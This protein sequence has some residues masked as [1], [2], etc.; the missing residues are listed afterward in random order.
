MTQSAHHELGASGAYRYLVC[1]GSVAAQRGKPEESSIYADEGTEAHELSEL[2]LLTWQGKTVVEKTAEWSKRIQEKGYDNA[3]MVRETTKYVEYVKD[4]CND[5]PKRLRVEARVGLSPAIPGGFSTA[6]AV[7]VSHENGTIRQIDIADLKYGKGKR[8]DA[9]ENP[10]L[11]LYAYGVIMELIDLGDID[12]MLD[13]LNEIA[14]RMHICQ[15]RLDHFDDDVM[16]VAQLL[17][18]VDST[19]IPSVEAIEAGDETRVAGDHCQFCKAEGNCKTR[20][21]FVTESLADD[22]DD[23]VEN[24]PRAE[25]VDELTAI[26]VGRILDHAKT[27]DAWLKSVKAH[28]YATIENGGHIPGHKIVEGRMTRKWS[29]EDAVLEM[30]KAQ[31]KLKQ[32]DYSPRK[33]ISPAQAEKALPRGSKILAEIVA[34]PGKPTLVDASNKKPALSFQ[35]VD[36]MFD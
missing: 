16:T 13:D 22:W 31:R 27:I 20:A 1:H 24:G 2:T 12:D 11:R 21:E 9:K 34:E 33:L 10:Q 7:I 26:E 30:F 4:L 6:D 23:F 17:D 5:D 19:V 32:D 18:W 25:K 35:T 15:P 28:A 8:V 14:V 29:D 3:E 36:E